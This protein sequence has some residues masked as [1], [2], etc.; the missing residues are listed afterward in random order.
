MHQ[1]GTLTPFRVIRMLFI[2]VVGT[3][4]VFLVMILMNQAAHEPEAKDVGPTVS[5]QVP[6]P[7][8][9]PEQKPPERERRPTTRT[10]QPALAPL[11]DLGSSLSGIAV[12][13]PDFQVEGVSNVSESLLGD[14]DD[15]ALTED[16]VDTPPSP[17]N[18]VI[19]VYP[20][21]AKQRDLEG[22]VLVSV[23]V[24]VDGQVK[25]VKILEANPPGV[26]DEAVATAVRQWTFG[27]A[28]YR[29]N[30]VESWVNIPFPFSLN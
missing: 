21:R 14:L 7:R 12:A 26:F 9:A 15:V 6:P 11:P 27:P 30:P 4:A 17:R 18:R 2:A 28:T 13:L 5:F 8:P 10:D 3:G 1:V 19:P 25:S 20:E 29:G 16:A 23:L 22:N 24:G